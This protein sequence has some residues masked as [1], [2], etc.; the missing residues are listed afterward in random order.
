MEILSLL[1]FQDPTLSQ[2]SPYL[3]GQSICLSVVVVDSSSFLQG[4][5]WCDPTLSAVTLNSLS[6][7]IPLVIFSIMTLNTIFYVYTPKFIYLAQ[8]PFLHIHK[9]NFLLYASFWILLGISNST[10]TNLN[11]ISILLNL[12]C[13]SFS[14]LS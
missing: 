14:H 5:C 3:T 10:C 6:I 11:I 1:S 9:S 7:L 13:L 4:K 2:V 8:T 12:L